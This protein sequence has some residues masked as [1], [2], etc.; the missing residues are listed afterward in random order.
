MWSRPL[1]RRRNSGGSDACG[2]VSSDF[3]TTPGDRTLF[4][5]FEP[6]LSG[7]DIASKDRDELIGLARIFDL[8]DP[9][10]TP[11]ETWSRL[12]AVL[13]RQSDFAP[14]VEPERSGLIVLVVEDDPV[15]GA[16]LA[17]LLG[18]AGHVVVGP[19]TTAEAAWLAITARA[20]IDVLVLDIN[21]AGPKTGVDL[22]ARVAGRGG[23]PVVFLSGDVTAGARHAT[24]AQRIVFKPWRDAEVLE[25]V[26]AA[27]DRAGIAA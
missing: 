3:A 5:R 26:A 7:Q 14:R 1:I 24:L 21:L 19:F 12:R 8:D 16:D 4:D 27:C 6:L 2:T 11:A 15:M 13:D 22:A 9:T 18:E 17:G 25:A 23:P 10:A 20:D